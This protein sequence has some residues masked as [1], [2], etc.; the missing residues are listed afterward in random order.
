MKAKS[1]IA[2][3]RATAPDGKPPVFFTVRP[4]DG[5]VV[6]VGDA[7]PV[8]QVV[9]VSSVH[10]S[11]ASKKH[12][13]R[14]VEPFDLSIDYALHD[15]ETGANLS[16]G[17]NGEHVFIDRPGALYVRMTAPVAVA[18]AILLGLKDW[19][20]QALAPTLKKP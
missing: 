5:R 11:P 20:L 1:F 16:E 3:V 15:R 9:K 12:T 19:E 8:G 17:A 2:V 14:V 10:Y 18:T 6:H 4:S 7:Y 13:A